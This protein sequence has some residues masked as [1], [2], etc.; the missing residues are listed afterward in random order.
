MDANT[1]AADRTLI[2]LNESGTVGL[3]APCTDNQTRSTKFS[4]SYLVEWAKRVD[5]VYGTE[6]EIVFTPDAPMAAVHPDDQENY[7]GVLIAPRRD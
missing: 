1:D 7:L 3:G 4:T 2:S 6:V 5:E